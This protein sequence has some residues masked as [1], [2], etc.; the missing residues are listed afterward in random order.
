MKVLE[1]MIKDAQELKAAHACIANVKDLE[2]DEGFRE[3]CAQNACGTY[4]TNWMCPPAVGPLED[5]Q[6]RI[7]QFEQGLL[8]QTVYYIED[9]FDWE[10]MAAAKAAH[11]V[12]FRRIFNHIRANYNLKEIYP[13]NAGCCK[14]CTECAYLEDKECYYPEEA[15]VSLEACGVDVSKLV[16]KY[17]IPYKHSS[18]AVCYVGLILFK[19]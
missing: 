17:N 9:S 10:G 11:E 3:L 4:N 14:Y 13:L 12:I 6:K 16:K 2:F 19:L 7:F 18:N 8:F 5:L 1:Q 15:V